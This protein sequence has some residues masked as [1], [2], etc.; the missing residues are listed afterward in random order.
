MAGVC[1]GSADASG[2]HYYP[3]SDNVVSDVTCGLGSGPGIGNVIVITVMASYHITYISLQPLC[4]PMM[5]RLNGRKCLQKMF[6][7]NIFFDIE[8]CNLNVLNTLH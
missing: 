8:E 3:R 1:R 7:M 4:L 2:N 5:D 6:I